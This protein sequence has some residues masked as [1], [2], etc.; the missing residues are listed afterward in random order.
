VLVGFERTVMVRVS[1]GRTI[2]G[3]GGGP[4][5]LQDE[6]PDLR[7][8]YCP[9]VGAVDEETIKKYIKS[10]KWEEDDQGFKITAPTEP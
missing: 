7:Q 2:Q 5:K 3:H 4:C 6:F 10:Q 1:S 9:S 8:R